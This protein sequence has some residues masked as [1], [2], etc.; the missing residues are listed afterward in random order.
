M[1]WRLVW[2]S[3]PSPSL[4]YF[5]YFCFV[6]YFLKYGVEDGQDVITS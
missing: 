4:I 1:P 3:L 2:L 6:F 5:I